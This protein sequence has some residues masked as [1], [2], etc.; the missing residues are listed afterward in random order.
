MREHHVSRE[1]IDCVQRQWT[2]ERL[3]EVPMQTFDDNGRGVLRRHC[4][5]AH[6]GLG[7][8]DEVFRCFTLRQ[9]NGLRVDRVTLWNCVNR[10][11]CA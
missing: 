8:I 11:V 2:F 10:I 7:R 6:L 4:I 9:L 3:Q 5:Q 1:P